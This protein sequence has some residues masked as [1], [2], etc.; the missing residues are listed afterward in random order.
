MIWKHLLAISVFAVILS[1]YANAQTS[2]FTYQ[3]RLTENLIAGNGPYDFTFKLYDQL[4]GGSQIG[5]DIVI[6]DANVAGGIFTVNLDFG[7]AA[8]TNG[9]PRFLQ[10]EVRAGA[11]TGAYTVLTPRQPITS[12]P[13]SVKS[14][15]TDNL[16]GVASSGYIQTAGGTITG[17]LTV[18]G[19]ITGN[20]SGLTSLNVNNLSGI[21][22]IASGGTGSSTKN[23]VDLSTDQTIAGNKTFTGSGFIRT[24][25]RAQGYNQPETID[26]GPLPTRVV[27]FT[28]LRSDTGLRVTYTDNVRVLGTNVAGRWEVRFNGAPAPVF[29]LAWD[30]YVT[31]TSVFT[32]QSTTMVGTAFGLPA[33][34]HSVRVYVG[35][36][37]GYPVTDLYTGWL[38]A[39]S[40]EVEEVL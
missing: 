36:T 40:L 30:F 12:A 4:S 26:N 37:P 20:G 34:V 32:H 31:S 29:P 23:F 9:G 1:A 16:G 3:G 15:D 5:T 33:G 8:F 24:I 27:S 35:Q 28:K 7:A 2:V 6:A 22:P 19:A 38:G 11:S 18:N 13:Y 10:V 14:M 39:W 25:V 21:L 17:N